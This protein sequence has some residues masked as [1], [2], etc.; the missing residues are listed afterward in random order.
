MT[1]ELRLLGAVE[2]VAD[3][4]PVA[5][6]G[7]KPRQ[8]LAA[9]LLNADRLVGTD[10]LVEAVWGADPPRSAM[11]NLRTYATALRKGLSGGEMQL[12]TSRTGF[13]LRTGDAKVDLDAFR[14]AVSA[15][16]GATAAGDHATAVSRYAE[17]ALYWRGPAGEGLPRDGWLGLALDALDEQHLGVLEERADTQ[18]R[19][20]QHA[21][22]LPQLVRLATEHPLRE[23]I[24]RLL[25]LAQYRGGNM[26]AAL[27]T[28]TR[29]R[30][31]LA[32]QLGVDPSAEFGALHAAILRRDPRLDPPADRTPPLPRAGRHT[33]VP[34]QLPA[35][36]TCFAGRHTE[37]AQAVAALREAP[38]RPVTVAF[39]GPAGI[40]SSAMALRAAHAVRDEFPDGQLYLDLREFTGSDDA[41]ACAAAQRLLRG[42][43]RSTAAPQTA[44]EAG[45][46]VR[47]ELAGLRVLVVVDN[48]TGP[49]PVRAL[50]PAHPGAAVIVAGLTAL[51]LPGVTHT[52][53]L[54][55][56]DYPSA[57]RI[58]EQALGPARARHERHAVQD[59]A[60]MCAGVPVALR[61]VATR[62]AARTNWSAA[63]TR[64]RLVS[65]HQRL[66]ELSYGGDSVRA[67]IAAA[68][69]A[70]TEA[71]P[72][73]RRVFAHLARC[74][75]PFDI[76]AA[77]QACP[78]PDSDVAEALERLVDF[79]LLDTVAPE[80][81]RFPELTRLFAVEL[82]QNAGTSYL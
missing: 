63:T 23:G 39:H 50:L 32:E 38:V 14:V 31:V 51:E 47:T 78:E 80:H 40:G 8:L 49:V 9:L 16:R 4:R 52:V 69:T 6:D 2:I 33:V 3:G 21:E 11:E 71:R 34:R 19:L 53:P 43:G 22:I 37:L 36:S 57:V 13:V 66:A 25:A 62:L 61:A 55:P 28:C 5:I 45:A 30:A 20:G 65:E 17:A 56:L 77:G 35:R 67:C 75:T 59:I 1:T 18:L 76:G 29:L 79:G 46:L 41:M 7:R 54:G 44:A 12:T 48:A 82:L 74:D 60:R 73:V 27:D 68:L 81:Y 42:L 15:A 26:S 10:R 64:D 72:A 24:W 70:A 58:L